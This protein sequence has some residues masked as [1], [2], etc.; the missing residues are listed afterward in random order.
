MAR[1]FSNKRL[2]ALLISLILLTVLVSFTVRERANVTWPEKIL[3]DVTSWMQGLVYRPV[4]HLS[5]FI[6]DVEQIFSLYQENAA[7]KENLRDYATLNARLKEA[8]QRNKQLQTMLNFRDGD[9]S[10]PYKMYPANVTGRSPDK[11]NSSIVIDKGEKDG[12]K[13]D[14]AVIAPEG[15]LVGRVMEVGEFSSKVLLIT[16]TNR[17]GISAMEQETRAVGIVNGSSS[18]PGAVEMGLIDREARLAAGQTVVTSNL[19]DIFPPG[20]PIGTITSVALEDTGLT[21][22]AI[23]K[24]TANLDRLEVVFYLERDSTPAK[25][26]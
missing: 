8:E 18:S 25:G 19:S 2:L 7:L 10:R 9:K 16:D 21:R 26:Q 1:F 3:I 15:G 24:P 5:G 6:D 12:V 20:I 4:S 14:M 11:W 22:K 13:K 23:L 17:M